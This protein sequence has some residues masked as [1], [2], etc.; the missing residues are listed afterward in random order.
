MQAIEQEVPSFAGLVKL[1]GATFLPE[2]VTSATDGEATIACIRQT[3]LGDWRKRV[4]KKVEKPERSDFGDN[5]AAGAGPVC[6]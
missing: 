3:P 2:M 6:R 4:G 1:I 5:L